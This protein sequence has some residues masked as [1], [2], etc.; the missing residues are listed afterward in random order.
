MFI[1]RPPAT[2]YAP[3]YAA[4]VSRIATDVEPVS[5]LE[6]Q[7]DEILRLLRSSSEQGSAHRYAPGKWSIK[8]SVGHMTDAERVFAYRLLRIARG[9][10]TPLPGFDENLFV[11]N[12]SFDDVAYADLVRNWAAVREATVTLMRTVSTDAWT[13]LGTASDKPVSA[14]ALLYI[15]LG[16]A[17]HHRE[18]LTARY[19]LVAAP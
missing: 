2:E 3:A 14:R 8:Q 7:R 4:Y 1:A 12:A 10:V 16:H 15:I 5:A 19:G 13:H 6:S 9:D 18:L 17:D 11:A